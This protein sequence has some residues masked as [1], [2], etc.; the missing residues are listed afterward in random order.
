MELLVLGGT[1]FVGRA[2]V[3]DALD[4]G[5]SVTA[6][7]RGLTGSNPPWVRHIT[8]DRHAIGAALDGLQFDAAVDTWSGT[9]SSVAVPA[10]RFCYVSSLSVYCDPVVVGSDEGAP[11][12]APGTDDYAADKLGGELA[13]IALFPDALLA[14]CGLI[15]GPWEN[16]GRLPWWLTRIA[17][18][19]RVVAPGSPSQP[20]QYVDVRDL[21]AWIND[22]LLTDSSGPY[23]L[24]CPGD[25]TTWGEV[26]QACI[27]VTGSDAELVWID[28][29]AVLAAGAEPWT[30][31]PIWVPAD[32]EWAG[33]FAFDTSRAVGT[34]L[35]SRA[36]AETVRDTWS[37]FQAEGSPTPPSHRPAPGLPAALESA[38]LGR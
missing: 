17:A 24:T 11:L 35:S 26:L 21:A 19:G 9:P 30:Q 22:N 1:Q 10:Q 36:I 32:G 25:H 18:G 7:N 34:G 38:L 12:V 6:L 28:Q 23:N 3:L 37:W 8:A 27:E 20:I 16:I 29:E 14:R 15:L 13:A 5:W 2:V 33:F 31:L 4:R